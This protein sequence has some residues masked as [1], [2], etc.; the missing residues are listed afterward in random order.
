MRGGLWSGINM[1][2]IHRLQLVGAVGTTQRRVISSVTTPPRCR[3][4]EGQ[5]G[6]LFG[7]LGAGRLNRLLPPHSSPHS[8]VVS[9]L[10]T[11]ASTRLEVSWA[12]WLDWLGWLDRGFKCG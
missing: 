12:D 4:G 5:P 6:R 1:L 10:V 9:T 3:V 7:E 8:S 2:V 11:D